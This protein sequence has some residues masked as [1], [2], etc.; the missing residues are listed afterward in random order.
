M[1][2]RARAPRAP[3]RA[4]C[5]LDIRA[6]CGQTGYRVRPARSRAGGLARTTGHGPNAGHLRPCP[7]SS[8]RARSYD[9]RTAPGV[10][11]AAR[12]VPGRGRADRWAHPAGRYRWSTRPPGSP[13]HR[14]VLVHTVVPNGDRPPPGM[15]LPS[16][17]RPVGPC[18]QSRNPAALH[19][20]HAPPDR[21]DRQPPA[22]HARLS[23]LRATRSSK[24]RTPPR[25]RS[26]RSA[27]TWRAPGQTGRRACT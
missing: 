17:P 8:L 4:R 13:G 7:S 3:A 9:I 5:E 14:F 26:T 16:F 27:A 21:P 22:R 23:P 15:P 10:P 25:S 12:A 19:G 20:V 6:A 11:R 18:A 24:L 2:G 1:G